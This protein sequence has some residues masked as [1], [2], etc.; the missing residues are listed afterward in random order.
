MPAFNAEKYI[1]E[2]IKS[3]INQT[4]KNWELLIMDDG[5]TD[6]TLQIAKSYI[7]SKIQVYSGD[8][9]GQSF[10]LNKAIL[11][12]NGEYI[13][14]MHADDLCLPERLQMQVDLM[15]KNLDYG[16]C[17]SYI[18]LF[19][20]EDKIF[21]YPI[22]PSLC[23]LGLYYGNPLAHSSVMLRTYLFKTFNIFYD[24]CLRVAEDY[25][26]WIRLTDYT[27]I[28]NVDKVLVK[29]R[30][31]E[32]QLSQVQKQLEE[33][34]VILSRQRLVAQLCNNNNNVIPIIINFLY[35]PNKL[36]LKE[37]WFAAKKF[38]DLILLKKN[39]AKKDINK[40]ALEILKKNL[41]AIPYS[42]RFYSLLR[43]PQAFMEW[44]VKDMTAIIISIFLRRSH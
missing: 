16:V 11:K 9:E 30:I 13:A 1:S 36:T 24:S 2:S 20:K 23:Y 41:L 10:Q 44:G 37:H 12:A 22:S 39:I 42:K 40:L 7:T 27:L 21:E 14:I 28:C 26:L 19:D 18:Q 25:D 6:N 17:G 33:E 31:H 4:Y 8:N 32:Q 5:S 3:V 15:G 38:N 34:Q 43:I 29:Y 35:Y